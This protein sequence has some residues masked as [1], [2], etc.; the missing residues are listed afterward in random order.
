MKDLPEA[1]RSLLDQPV[2]A[3]V[4]TTN[5]DGSPQSSVVWIERVGNDVALF[6]SSSSVKVRNFS[7]NPSA[8]VVVVD[9]SRTFEPGAQCHV[10][11][12]GVAS[13]TPMTDTV[14]CDRL[15]G[16][17]MGLDAFPHAGEYVMIKITTTSWSGIGPIEDSPH[18]WGQ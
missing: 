16:K 12:T 6:S 17:Y 13:V 11:L 3:V 18:G 7:R 15:A 1:V 2:S 9:P 14:F 4:S 5:A 8:V 10:L